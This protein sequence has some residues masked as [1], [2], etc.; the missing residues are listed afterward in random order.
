MR[1]LSRRRNWRV[2]GVSLTTR[3]LAV[4]VIALALLAGSFFYL[5]SYRKQLL[6]ERFSLARTEAEIAAI[7][8]TEAGPRQRRA[9]LAEIGTAQ[10]LRLHALQCRRGAYR[11]QLPPCP[12]PPFAF[13]DPAQE[14]WYQTAARVLDRGVDLIVGAP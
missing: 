12:E 2:R 3:I 10:R 6:A 4:N 5:D 7:A 9:V 1:A 11:R 8:L 13:A 14:A